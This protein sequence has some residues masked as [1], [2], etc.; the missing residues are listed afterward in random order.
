[1]LRIIVGSTGAIAL[2]AFGVAALG[3]E[4]LQPEALGA[5]LQQGKMLLLL[6]G[7]AG[8]SLA[9]AVPGR[10]LQPARVRR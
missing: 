7:L 2:L 10:R 5:F 3:A 4:D 8:I 1:M 6:G 9:A